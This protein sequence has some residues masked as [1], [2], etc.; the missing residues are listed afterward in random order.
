M[1]NL[2]FYLN[3]YN[4]ED[5]RKISLENSLNIP[6]GI[7]TIICILQFYLIKEFDY[8]ISL[9]FEKVILILFVSISFIATLITTYYLLKSYHN[10]YKGF[11]YKGLPYPSQLLDYKDKL[12]SYYKEYKNNYPGID[13]EKEYEKYLLNKYVTFIDQNAYNND[14]RSKSLHSS[15][16][17][18]FCAIFSIFIASVPFIHNFF[19]QPVKTYTIEFKNYNS[20]DNRLKKLENYVQSTKPTNSSSSSS[21]SG[22]MDKRR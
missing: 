11:E 14:F 16:R 7:I 22:Q 9:M 20:I 13:V 15:K 2:E 12:T 1:N 10:I 19:K 4:K 21:S 17:Y 6:I 18:L 3:W 5:E 8:G